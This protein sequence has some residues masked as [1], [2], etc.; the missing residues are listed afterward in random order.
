MTNKII[1]EH[2]TFYISDVIL[3][4]EYLHSKNIVY[5]DLKPENIIISMSAHGHI[6]LCDFGFAKK[7][8]KD[9]KTKTNCGTPTFLAPE[10]LFGKGHSLEVD[11]WA[12]GVLIYEIVVGMNPF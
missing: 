10:I 4:L 6:K 5:R 3:A 7:I 11:I 9:Q 8:S 2:M 12:L 1:K